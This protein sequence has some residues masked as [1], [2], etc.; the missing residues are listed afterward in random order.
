MSTLPLLNK[1]KGFNGA[2][3]PFKNMNMI[4]GI[5]LQELPSK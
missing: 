2:G 3:A 5:S 4:K 1:D